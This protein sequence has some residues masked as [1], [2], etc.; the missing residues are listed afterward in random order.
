[1]GQSSLSKRA[2]ATWLLHDDALAK[3]L[4]PDGRRPIAGREGRVPVEAARTSE[5][6]SQAVHAPVEPAAVSRV[7]VETIS[8]RGTT[9]RGAWWVIKHCSGIMMLSR[10]HIYVIF[11]R[12]H[13]FM[14]MVYFYNCARERRP[15]SFWAL[16]VYMYV[17]G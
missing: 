15:A 16:F 12:S 6:E 14:I 11:I 4:L 7:G 2:K 17:K 10:G 13:V 5:A 8:S 9:E 3:K 1:M